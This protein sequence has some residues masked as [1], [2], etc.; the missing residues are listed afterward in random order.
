MNS[1][2]PVDGGLVRLKTILQLLQISKSSF[3]AGIA[4]G[5]FPR[6]IKLGRSSAWTLSSIKKIFAEE[7][8]IAADAAATAGPGVSSNKQTEGGSK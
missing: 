5:R 4:A 2:A 3:Y 6:P 7:R 8:A 1:Q